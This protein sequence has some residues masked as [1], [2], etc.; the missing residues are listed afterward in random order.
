M[1]KVI[2][3]F[4]IL[5]PACILACSSAPDTHPTESASSAVA[6]HVP[7]DINGDGLADIALTSGGPNWNTVPVAFS[8]GS[9]SFYVT[10]YPA[11]T[12]A[13]FS[14]QD[15]AQAVAG[16]FN[17]DGFTD[18]ALTGGLGWGS[19]PV[20]FSNGDGTFRVTNYGISGF[21][22]FAAESNVR[23]VAGDFN[24]DGRSDIALAGGIGWATVPVAF[25]NGDGTFEVTND[26][27]SNFPFYA[28]QLGA[29]LVAADFNNDHYADLA[30][31]GGT[32]NGVAWTTVPVAFSNG[33]GTFRVTNDAVTNFPTYAVQ[34][35]LAVAGDFNRDGYG[36]IAL[37]GGKV[38][39]TEAPWGSIPVAFSNGDGTF[40]V[41]NTAVSNFGTYAV[42]N[43]QVLAADFNGDG[44]CDLALTGGSSGGVP[45]TTIPVAFSNGDGSF[46]VTNDTVPLFPTA[47]TQDVYGYTFSYG[48]TALSASD[49]HQR[50]LP[51]VL[52]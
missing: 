1:S 4:P 52:Q 28:N 25:S 8:S 45:W 9:G 16:D 49:G 31:V 51:L 37:T 43:A 23:V 12:F 21:A 6:T 42:Q 2:R 47:A 7:G 24:G 29:Q 34:G 3:L 32:S 39:S 17:N 40:R 35:A 26:V 30:L 13:G 14:V 48:A 50:F 33:D 46:A 19:L 11:A 27:V 5:V 22:T 10:N 38:P 44:Y 36:D 18:L 15:G 41:T 20:A